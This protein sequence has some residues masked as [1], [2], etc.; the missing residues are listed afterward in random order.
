MVPTGYSL[1]GTLVLK[2]RTASFSFSGSAFLMYV[3]LILCPSR[4]QVKEFSETVTSCA[5]TL[6]TI[7]RNKVNAVPVKRVVIVFIATPFNGAPWRYEKAA[8][9]Y[10]SLKTN[11]SSLQLPT[12]GVRPTIHVEHLS[13][14]LTCFCQVENSVDNVFYGGDLPHWLQG[15][16]KV[17]GIILVQRCVHDAG[18]DRVEADTFFCVLDCE[19]SGHRIQAALRNHRNRGIDAGDG[20]IGKRSGDRHDVP[21]LLF[22]HLFHGELSNIEESQQ[23]DRGQGVEVVGSK[24]RERLGVENSG[25]IHQNVDRSEVLDR[26]FDSFESGLLLTNIAIDQDQVG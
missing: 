18:G 26:C 17:L 14:H 11:R 22:E 3:F 1:S 20:I 25:V 10:F 5:Y 7:E 2:T 21:G 4:I 13:G 19:T 6:H 23:V 9:P 12:T 8:R 24:V 15:L 16:K